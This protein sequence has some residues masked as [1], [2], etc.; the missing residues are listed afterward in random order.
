MKNKTAFIWDK[1]SDQPYIIKDKVYKNSMRNISKKDLFS[2]LLSNLIHFPL[3]LAFSFVFKSKQ[4]E[5]PNFFG[6][7]VNIDKGDEQVELLEELGCDDI[8][9]RVPL[10]KI[11]KIQE[12]VAFAKKFKNKNILIN[13]LQD[14]EHIENRAKLRESITLLFSSFKGISNTFQIAN[15]INRTKWGFFSVAEYLDF[16]SLVYEVRNE[17]FKEFILVGPS[18]IDFEYHYTIRALFNKYPIKYDKLSS[19]L[20]VDRRG[21]PENTQMGI[22]DTSKKIDFLYSLSKLSIRSS[23]DILITEVNWPLSNTAPF[24]PT[25][26]KECIDEDTYTNYML[27]YYFL[28]LGSKKVQTVYWHQLIAPGYGLVDQR[29]GLRKRSSFKAYKFMISLLEDASIENFT[30][31]KDLYVLTCKGKKGKFDIIWCSSDRKI[32]LEEQ[33]LVFNRFGEEL[34]NDIKISNEPIYAF[35]KKGL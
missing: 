31:S 17:K 27:R 4:K 19:L 20:Y 16:Y 18:V 7:C 11:Q 1:Y 30:N 15:A 28:A 33:T 2:L 23:S 8:Q 24:A 13:I 5:F 32:D 21:A 9:I 29:E 25:S 14:R 3:S 12:Y 22:F 26:E 35:H 10:A 6:M 34:K